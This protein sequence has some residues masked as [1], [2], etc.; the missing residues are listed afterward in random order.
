MSRLSPLEPDDLDREERAVLEA[1]RSGPRASRHGRVGLVGPYSVWVRAP[2]VGMAA[3]ALGAA[4]R[5]ETALSEALKEVAVCT[6]GAFHHAKF[7]FAAHRRLAVAAGVDET[8][9]ERLR[10]GARLRRRRGA[11]P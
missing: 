7:E 10:R 3:Q 2:K 9:I 11:G 6:V 4:V 1:I 5:F 8:A